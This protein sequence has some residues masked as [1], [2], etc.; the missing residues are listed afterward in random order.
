MKAKK[1]M[2]IAL[3]GFLGLGTFAFSYGEDIEKACFDGNNIQAC[4]KLCEQEMSACKMAG[5]LHLKDKDYEGAIPYFE[6][7]CKAL[8]KNCGLLGVSYLLSGQEEK[9]LEPLK[10]AC[11]LQDHVG[12][13]G[14]GEYYEKAKQDLN[15]AYKYYDKACKLGNKHACNAINGLKNKGINQ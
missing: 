5:I 11:D 1:L 4:E 10:T 2:A 12:C 15:L 14:L 13:I 6:K 9:A 8:K 7:T 3:T